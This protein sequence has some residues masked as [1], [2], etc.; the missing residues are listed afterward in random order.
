MNENMSDILERNREIYSVWYSVF[1]FN[2]HEFMVKPDKFHRSTKLPIL[3]DIVLFKFSDSG[4][5]KSE[6]VW[7]LGS[8]RGLLQEVT[9]GVQ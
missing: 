5:G 6:L 2:I 4:Y 3:G 1:M 7:K 9:V 8:D